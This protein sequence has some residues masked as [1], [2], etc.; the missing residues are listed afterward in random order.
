MIIGEANKLK[1]KWMGNYKKNRCNCRVCGFNQGFDPWGKNGET[2]IFDTCKCCGI[3]FGREDCNLHDAQEQRTRW[4]RN[5][6]KWFPAND[7]PQKWSLEEQ[8]KNIPLEYK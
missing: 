4:L 3:Q 6:S 8:L 7:R 2:P 5:D 1:T